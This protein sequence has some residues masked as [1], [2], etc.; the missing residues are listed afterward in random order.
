M[1]KELEVETEECKKENSEVKAKVTFKE[2]INIWTKNKKEKSK[3]KNISEKSEKDPQNE[4]INEIACIAITVFIACTMFILADAFFR[5]VTWERCDLRME[6]IKFAIF[7]GIII[8]TLLLAM[9]KNSGTATLVGCIGIFLISIINEVKIMFTSE[10]LYFAD[11]NFLSKAGDLA[12]LVTGNI[13]NSFLW[14]F[15]AIAGVFLWILGVIT[16]LS[17]TFSISIKNK[18]IRISIIL[19]DLF[20]L[21]MLFLPNKY[22]KDFYLRTFF[23]TDKYVDFDSYTTN[24]QF[25]QRNGFINGM[26]GTWLNSVFVEPDN[27]NEEE[28]EKILK[29]ALEANEKQNNNGKPNIVVIFSEAFWDIDVLDEIEF[30]KPVTSNFN[31]LKQEG[32]LVNIISPSYGGMSENVSFELL[33]GGSMNYFSRG[34]IPIMSL[35]SRKN[36]EEAPSII[37]NLKNNGYKTEITF[38]KD[39]YNS[40]AAYLKMGFDKYDEMAEYTTFYKNDQY[41]IGTLIKRLENKTEEPLFSILATMEGHMPF[42]KRKY[43]EYDI[44]ITK[45]N[46]SEKANNTILS[47]TQGVYNADEQLGVLYEFIQ[48]FDEPTILIFLGDHLPYMYTA[49]GDNVIDKLEYF[50]TSDELL[51]NYRLYNPQALIVSNYDAKLEIPEYLGTDMLLNCVVNQ[52]DVECEPYYKWLYQTMEILPGINRNIAFDKTGKLYNP[53]EITDE[54]QEIYETKRSMQ[55][56]FFIDK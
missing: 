2:K 9:F 24:L 20:I 21:L 50:N 42:S 55:Y 41:T 25:Y 29:L 48:N 18:K 30:D 27:Y 38:G 34:Y 12:G 36:I 15:V 35:Y 23:N 4:A 3:S 44:S 10:P 49:E 26:Y 39:F 33:T 47:Y 1:E 13:S 14:K 53:K 5:I 17:Y 7:F 16:F 37:K 45:S 40:K 6:S 31:K 51:N 8:Y 19:I 46:L 56:K 11:I 54:M 52:L 32:K 28:L 43:N 22:T